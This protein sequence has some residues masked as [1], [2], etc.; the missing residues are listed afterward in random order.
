MSTELIPFSKPDI[1]A[2]EVEA[3]TRVLD[4]GWVTSGP[5]SLAFE[6]EF[7]KYF[8]GIEAVAVNSATAGLHLALE[9]IGIGEGDEVLVPTW[10]FTAT[11]EVVRYLGATPVLVDV[12]PVTL[13][14]NIGAA[15]RAVTSR[16]KAL[17]VVHFAGLSVDMPL[18]ANVFDGTGIKIIED[19]A[20]ALPSSAQGVAV[21]SAE[22]S[23]ATVFSFYANKTM[24]TGEGGM[25]TT[26]SPELTA[27]IRTMRLHGIDRDVFGR[28]HSDR[29]SW[30]YDVVAPGFK[31]NLPDIAASIGRVQF[32]RMPEMAK[33]RE[34]IAKHY[35]SEMH[36]LP[37][38]LP[39]DALAEDRHSWHLFVVRLQPE[40]RVS[41][42][43]L[44]SELADR[45][46]G[47]SV[48]FIPLHRMSYWKKS[49]GVSSNNFPVAESAFDGALSLPL[50]SKM[51]DSDVVRI[52]D[53]MKDV[54]SA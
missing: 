45:R 29:P 39:L 5:E 14:I 47:T 4:S 22:F 37:L 23:E 52:V 17:I 38:Q 35:L 49:L 8:G 12:D 16:T 31:Y 44:M 50:Y 43:E 54:L 20:H 2:E 9:A 40:A 1:G 46:I 19:A 36:G 48:H 42:D 18:L 13:N 32:R 30:Q 26:R 51:N 7:S 25:V 28:Y 3:V 21:G 34:E 10:T 11:A 41:R 53:T 6:S 33:R 27:R 15:K 24:T